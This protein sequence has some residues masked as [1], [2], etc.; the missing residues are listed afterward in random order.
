MT[1][2]FNL[3]DDANDPESLTQLIHK[4]VTSCSVSFPLVMADKQRIM[5]SFL[6]NPLWIGYTQQTSVFVKRP[7]MEQSWHRC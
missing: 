3:G 7:V 1:N 6:T 5:R 4:K 2:P